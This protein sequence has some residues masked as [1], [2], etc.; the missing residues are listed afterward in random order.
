M[1]RRPGRAGPVRTG[2][3]RRPSEPRIRE[4]VADLD[5]G[6]GPSIFGLSSFEPVS[7]VLAVAG[8]A[9]SS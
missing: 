1:S 6:R 3:A 4:P 5:R 9:I 7:P 2:P 8:P